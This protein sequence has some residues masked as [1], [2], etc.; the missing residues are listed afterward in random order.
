[1]SKMAAFLLIYTG[2]G[3]FQAVAWGQPL[4]QRVARLGR[5]ARSL[6]R[7][8]ALACLAAAAVLVAMGLS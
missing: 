1:M 7:L 2:C 5:R 4:A 8:P 3:L 6:A